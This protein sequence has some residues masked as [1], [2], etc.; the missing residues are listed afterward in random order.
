MKNEKT[1][2]SGSVI[3]SF[4]GRWEEALCSGNV[5]VFFRKKR[6]VT[7][8]ERVFFYVGV[9]VKRIIGYAYIDDIDLVNFNEAVSIR[10]QGCITENELIKY[11]GSGGSVYA[12]KI[13]KTVIFRVPIDLEY[14]SEEFGFNPPQSF[15]NVSNRFERR[16]L[17]NEQ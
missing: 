5:R 1:E 3:Y 4:N 15:S 11:I 7:L 17:E 2:R 9:P 8:P 6:P 12:L 13:R 16:L 14:L 10:H